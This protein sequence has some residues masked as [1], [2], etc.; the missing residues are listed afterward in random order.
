MNGRVDLID[1]PDGPAQ[2]RSSIDR[3]LLYLSV[4]IFV[5][6]WRLF[7]ALWLLILFSVAIILCSVAIILS[8]VLQSQATLLF[9]RD[10][11]GSFVSGICVSGFR[12]SDLRFRYWG[13]DL[14]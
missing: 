12:I 10:S 6:L 3:F 9:E 8:S 7:S 2:K 1:R 4:A 13:A 5:H 11:Q 14:E